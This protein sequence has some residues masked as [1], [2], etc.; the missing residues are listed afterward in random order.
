MSEIKERMEKAV[1]ATEREWAKIR[2]GMATPALLD[3][4]MVDYY[5]TPTAVSH[6][7]KI[8]V[9]EPRMLMISP[10][11]KPMLAEIEKAILTA[12]LGVT[13]TN[14]GDFIRITMPIL[15]EDRRKDL[16]KQVRQIAEDGKIAVRNIRRDE[17]DKIKKTGKDDG[18]SEDEIKKELDG[19]QKTTDGFI[20]RIDELCK[21]K[22]DDVL[23]V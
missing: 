10:W 1:L 19:V 12:N 4:V 7:A 14:D 5:G 9:P 11:E 3:S 6:L 20:A 17:N 22:E 18:L 2:T 23:K 16:A 8:T 21:K 13:P 15:T